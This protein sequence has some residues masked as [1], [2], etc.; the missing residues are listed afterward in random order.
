M[1]DAATADV[2]VAVCSLYEDVLPD[3]KFSAIICIILASLLG[4]AGI[5]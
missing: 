2:V 1:F 3:C 4:R 5:V